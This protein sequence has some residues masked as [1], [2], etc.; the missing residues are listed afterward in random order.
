MKVDRPSA[1]ALLI[2][3][4]LLRDS[5]DP[6][7][8]AFVPAEAQR[9][10]QAALQHASAG[11]ARLERHLAGWPT[12]A[13]TGWLEGATLPGI[14]AHYLY[15]KRQLRQWA[16]QALGE[17]CRQLVV[18]GAGFDTLSLEL[19]AKEA[20]LH[21]IEIDHPATQSVKR[22]AVE[23][24]ARPPAFAEADLVAQPLRCALDAAGFR[25][26]LSTLF[27]AEGLAMYLAPA[28]ARQL[29]RE[30]RRSCPQGTVAFS[31]MQPDARGRARFHSA[32]PWL[33]A[34]LS[35][36]GE[37]FRWAASRQRVAAWLA[38][39]GLSVIEVLDGAGLR[40]RHGSTMDGATCEGEVYLLARWT[41]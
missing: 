33:Q 28:R 32:R 31:F 35:L 13:V 26:E 24:Q 11:W 18:L 1:T 10:G 21:C 20:E 37:P 27:V 39:Q 7:R 40:A 16:A 4:S 38:R 8:R 12:R 14:T 34:W 2:A 22:R 41:A 15:R 25:P 36:V 23:G 5:H 3:A 9:V 19:S 29:L 6:R 30:L 17:G